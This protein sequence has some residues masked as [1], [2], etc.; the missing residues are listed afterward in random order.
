LL[1]RSTFSGSGKYTGH[2]LGENHRTFEDMKLSIAGIM[3]FN[4]FGIPL[5]GANVCGYIS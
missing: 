5:V 2:W 1:S 4:L 3:N